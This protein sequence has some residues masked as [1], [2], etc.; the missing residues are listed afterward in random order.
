MLWRRDAAVGLLANRGSALGLSG[1]L[2]LVAAVLSSPSR[3]VAF[4]SIAGTRSI[5]GRLSF[6][7]VVP[8]VASGLAVVSRQGGKQP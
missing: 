6:E 1:P 2:A 8:G 4:R 5:G 3:I 7:Q